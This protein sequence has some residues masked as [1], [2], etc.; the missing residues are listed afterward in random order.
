MAPEA[1]RAAHVKTRVWSRGSCGFS[2]ALRA[3]LTPTR[4]LPSPSREMPPNSRRTQ[5]ECGCKVPGLSREA[6]SV[7]KITWL[8]V[9]A[10]FMQPGLNGAC[11]GCTTRVR[12]AG[13]GEGSGQHTD[14]PTSKITYV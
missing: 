1:Q 2:A 3:P 10:G 8:R 13:G 9:H 5:Y 14:S 7:R 6:A 11:M 4:A 12:G